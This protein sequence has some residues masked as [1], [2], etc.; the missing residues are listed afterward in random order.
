M[1]TLENVKMKNKNLVRGYKFI[2]Q[3]YLK[4]NKL[5]RSLTTISCRHPQHSWFIFKPNPLLGF[6]IPSST[7][8][9][10]KLLCIDKF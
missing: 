8:V 6:L 1:Q 10:R 4:M 3:D 2:E 9:N 5:N 7:S